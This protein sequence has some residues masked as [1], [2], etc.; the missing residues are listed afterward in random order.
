[1]FWG[2]K[3]AHLSKAHNAVSTKLGPSPCTLIRGCPRIIRTWRDGIIA[4]IKK[5]LSF[6]PMFL[7]ADK[8]DNHKK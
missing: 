8:E 1:M 5:Q 2:R 7:N 6:F 4:K 3:V